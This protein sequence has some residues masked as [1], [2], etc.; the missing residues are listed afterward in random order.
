MTRD[1]ELLLLG[2][3]RPRTAHAQS[4]AGLGKRNNVGGYYR[5]AATPATCF[6]H[7][8]LMPYGSQARQGETRKARIR[9]NEK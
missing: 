1:E 9:P 8:L 3:P 2:R 4:T 5:F 6:L 7:Y